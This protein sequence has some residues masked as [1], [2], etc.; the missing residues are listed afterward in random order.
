MVGGPLPVVLVEWEDAC[1]RSQC[2]PLSKAH[3][4]AKLS[5][6]CT[7]GF[8]VHLGED[9]VTLAV[10]FDAA[11]AED[12]ED[13]VDDLFSI[14]RGWVR[15]IVTLRRGKGQAPAAAEVAQR[16]DAVE[17]GAPRLPA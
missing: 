5:V 12:A 1:L 16:E 15:R 2:E 17:A 10:T 8:L 7:V 9:R 6:R 4:A 14:P 11:E 13:H 3:A